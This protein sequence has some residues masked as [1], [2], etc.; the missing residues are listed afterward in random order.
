MTRD[1]E[2][3]INLDQMTDGDVRDL[4]RQQLDEL[5]DFDVD[6]VDISVEDGR[7]RVEGRV[8]TEAERQHVD[9]VITSLGATAY[10]NNLTVD[11]VARAQRAEAADVA[12]IEDAE[13]SASV[14]ES[15]KSTSDTA[16]HLE[17][18]DRSDLYGT[19]DVGEAIEEGRSYTPPDGPVQEGIEGDERH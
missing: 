6:A 12:R 1:F 11:E 5:D 9:Q 3:A 4:V 16:E 19:K 2:D 18:G 10:A 7:I 15:G 13:A 17:T 14:G 8:G